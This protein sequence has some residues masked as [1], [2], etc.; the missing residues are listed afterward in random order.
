[1]VSNKYNFYVPIW[2][3]DW[4]VQDV[5]PSNTVNGKPI[6]YWVNKT[7]QTVPLDA[8]FVALIN[9]T[10]ITA[11]DLRLA[12]NSQ[13]ILICSSSN[14]TIV[15]NAMTGNEMGVCLASAKNILVAENDVTGNVFGIFL[16]GDDC[17]IIHNNFVNN[18]VQSYCEY[19]HSNTWDDGYPSGGNYW[20]DFIGVDLYQGPYQNETG[21]DGIV[22]F[23]YYIESLNI[24]HYP[25]M[26]TWIPTPS[27]EHDIAAINLTAS[28][29]TVG[30]GYQC[31]INVT[32]E[33]QGQYA[34]T[35]Q[36]TLYANTTAIGQQ[37]I[38]NLPDGSAIIVEFNWNT[39]GYSKGNYTISVVAGSVPGETHTA[40]NTLVGSSVVV[41]IP[42]DVDGNSVVNIFDVVQITSRYG[43]TVPLMPPDSNADIDGNGVVNI[44]DVVICTSHYGQK[45]P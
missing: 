38:H 45:W 11:Q 5:D 20:S 35:F 32:V 25:L 15:R 6:Y 1:M 41:A 16:V 24:D 2:G 17:T 14:M 36:V 4:L 19:G 18:T 26:N 30:Q 39:G 37:T 44:F 21:S 28:K 42:G 27:G 34:E 13:G 8:G 10:R 23:P 12:N 9:C 22:D 40:D 31:R 7:D 43:K 33:N 3:I 29:S